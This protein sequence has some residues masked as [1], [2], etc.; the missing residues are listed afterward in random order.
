MSFWFVSS[1]K[2]SVGIDFA[3]FSNESRIKKRG[4]QEQQVKLKV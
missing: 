3:C 4:I 1:A 2:L